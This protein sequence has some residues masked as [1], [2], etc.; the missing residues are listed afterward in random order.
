VKRQKAEVKSEKL[1]PLRQSRPLGVK[2]EKELV[3]GQEP[4]QM[5]HPDAD[6]DLMHRILHGLAPFRKRSHARDPEINSG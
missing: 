1:E 5:R 2:S 3:R 6:Q 4:N